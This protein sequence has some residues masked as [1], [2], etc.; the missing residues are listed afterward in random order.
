MRRPGDNLIDEYIQEM[1]ELCRRIHMETALSTRFTYS[2][3]VD[4][5]TIEVYQGELSF[6]NLLVNEY[7]VI[8]EDVPDEWARCS[9]VVEELVK[10]LEEHKE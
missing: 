4:L 8:R 9:R 5:L 1:L 2:S 6:E 7:L 3:N 10:V